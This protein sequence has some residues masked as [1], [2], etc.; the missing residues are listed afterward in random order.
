MRHSIARALVALL[1]SAAAIVSVVGA[2]V[3]VPV[4][5]LFG[6]D[7]PSQTLGGYLFAIAVPF[8]VLALVIASLIWSVQL[9]RRRLDIA[10]V[11]VAAIVCSAM[12]YAGVRLR[13]H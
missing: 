11:L 12:F 7:D 5:V 2:A 8:I 6:R 1:G 10:A 4:I 3:Y 9:L 13:P